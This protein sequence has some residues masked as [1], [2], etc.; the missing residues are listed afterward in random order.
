MPSYNLFEK[1]E[2]VLTKDQITPNIVAYRREEFTFN[3]ITVKSTHR[4]FS[5]G[6]SLRLKL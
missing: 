2:T 3:N 6:L 4:L 1:S 5:I